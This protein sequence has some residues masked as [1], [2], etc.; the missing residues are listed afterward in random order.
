MALSCGLLGDP[1]M[2]TK[3]ALSSPDLAESII[4][5]PTHVL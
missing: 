3:E 4:Q 2:I 1:V 5:D